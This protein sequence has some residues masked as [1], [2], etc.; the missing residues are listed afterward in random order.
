VIRLLA[1][2]LALLLVSLPAAGHELR[3]A[4]LD[5][6][7]TEPGV[8]AVVWKVPARGDRRLGI[9]ARLPEICAPQAEPYRSIEG[10]A[11]FERVT[12]SCSAPLRGQ[13]IGIDGLSATFTD[14]LLRIAYLD[15]SVETARLTPE[16]AF[17]EIRGAQSNLEVTFTYFVL[18]I[19][20]ILEGIDHLLFVFALLLLV[21]DWRSLVKAVTAFTLAHSITLTGATLGYMSLPQAPVEAIIALSVVFVAREVIEGQRGHEGLSG[22]MPWIM[23]F[24]F[25]LLH[26]FGFAGALREVGLPQSD[27]PLALL[28]FNLGVEAGQLVFVAAVLLPVS[29]A[30]AMFRLEP[31]RYAM[32]AAYGAGAVATAWFIE[33]MAVII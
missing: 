32:T 29:L 7:E 12:V 27:V 9:A 31:R 15:G 26:G 6:R 21:R 20:H 25:G 33:R 19:E 13:Q 1:I 22:R 10:N 11:Y 28:S 16:A 23:A 24:A 14:A 2:C 8:F 3:P 5:L 17:T 30:R 4:Y 18:G